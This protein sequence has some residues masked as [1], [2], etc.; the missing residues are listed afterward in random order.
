MP[1]LFAATSPAERDQ[2][3]E[4]LVHFLASTG[5]LL[6]A[7]PIAPAVNRGEALFH[8]VGCVACHDAR[9]DG[10][11]HLPTSVPLPVE[12]EAKYSI[13]GLVAF[14][15]DP[16]HT[17]PSGRMPQLNLNDDEARDIASYLLKNLEAEGVIDFVYY[18]GS[19]QELPD[20]SKL[21]PVASGKTASFDVNVGKPDNFAAVFKAKV[22]IARDGKYRF[23]VGSDDGSRLKIDGQQVAEADGIH[24][25]SFQS[26][27]TELKAGIHEVEVE[28]FEQGGEQEL[29]V[30]FEGPGITRQALEY[31]LAPP[32][33]KPGDKPPFAVNAELA[34]RGRQ[35]FG[36]LGCAT[37]HQLQVDGKRLASLRS[38]KPLASLNL[39]A[40]CLSS[41]PANTPHYSLNE[42]QRASLKA[43][44]PSL[45]VEP[46]TDIAF[47]S[48]ST[49]ATALTAFNCY[50]C[51]Q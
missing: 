46:N 18:E 31:A 13:P 41:A 38:A 44:I 36:S 51:H 25:L 20:F 40:G 24:P 3:V 14:V 27:D 17:R 4:S 33:K 30:E 16:L 10:S 19:W 37:C 15:K 45:A 11:P 5:Q 47:A 28:Y 23:H 42:Q 34:S 8:N 6:E 26:G 21:T 32:A 50:A 49:I 35:L 39:A 43:A 7:G 48:E 1:N 22:Q 12:M 2:Q 29:R 9:R